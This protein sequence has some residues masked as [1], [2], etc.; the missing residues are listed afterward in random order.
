M[1]GD[2]NKELIDLES[3]KQLAILNVENDYNNHS[4]PHY[5]DNERF[6]WAIDSINKTFER[7]KGELIDSYLLF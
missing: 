2:L 5:R 4:S 7:D 3:K 1:E 6:K